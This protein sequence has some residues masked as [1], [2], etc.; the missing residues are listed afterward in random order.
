MLFASRFSNTSFR[1]GYVKKTVL[2]AQDQWRPL[3]LRIEIKSIHCLT[4]LLTNF[5]TATDCWWSAKRLHQHRQCKSPTASIMH[6]K[7]DLKSRQQTLFFP[8]SHTHTEF[9]DQCRHPPSI[10]VATSD[11][12][13]KQYKTPDL[14]L[15]AAPLFSK[16]KYIWIAYSSEKS[17]GWAL[18]FALIKTKGK[19]FS[20]TEEV[21]VYFQRRPVTGLL[22]GHESRDSMYILI[23][24][25]YW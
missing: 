16:G 18:H 15:L 3:W 24:S 8:Q 17:L 13:K 20:I 19:D 1:L 10:P 12:L 7:Q 11:L 5:D 22:C 14:K 6:L 2:I 23:R 4:C 21:R 9:E 25:H